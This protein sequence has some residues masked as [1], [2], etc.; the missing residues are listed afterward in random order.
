MTAAGA[1]YIRK[2]RRVA[3]RLGHPVDGFAVPG[4]LI[5]QQICYY[6]GGHVAY[7]TRPDLDKASRS[8]ILLIELL[9]EADG[10][11]ECAADFP[12]FRAHAASGTAGI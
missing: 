5:G 12:D 8:I 11:I 7:F 2:W 1:E 3:K 10:L 9:G 6:W 4:K